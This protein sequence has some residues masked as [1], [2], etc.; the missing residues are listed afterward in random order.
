MNVRVRLF[1]S[2]RQVAGRSSVELDLPDTATIGQLRQRLT[3]EFPAAA[4]VIGRA[5]FACDLQYACDHDP[6]TADAELA[7]IPPVSGG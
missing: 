7:C 3:A 5:M 6:I 4:A 1:A 2:V